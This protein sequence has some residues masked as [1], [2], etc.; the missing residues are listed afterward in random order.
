MRWPWC[1]SSQHCWR[2]SCWPLR[3]LALS[4]EV[5]GVIAGLALSVAVAFA[6]SLS[7]LVRLFIRFAE[8]WGRQRIV[9]WAKRNDID[10][11]EIL[12]D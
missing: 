2:L 6:M 5:K 12:D 4:S 3:F 1:G 10:P 8:A 9:R 11:D 7:R